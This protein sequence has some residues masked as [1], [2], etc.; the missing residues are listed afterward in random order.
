M[1]EFVGEQYIS[2]TDPTAV[3][4]SVGAAR[5]AAKQV[6]RDGASVRL[7]GSVF[8]PDDETC[9]H[10]YEAD[11]IQCVR[12]AAAYAG[13]RLER[14]APA[15]SDA[16]VFRADWSD[17]EPGCATPGGGADL[18]HKPTETKEEP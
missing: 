18:A 3:R 13:L 4:H 2:R 1:P 8:V 12:R 11:S 10:L 14:I 16:G 6:T 9:I 5:R 17:D 7:V 15:V